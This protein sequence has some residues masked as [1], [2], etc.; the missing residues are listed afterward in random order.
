[1]CLKGELSGLSS[2]CVCL[3]SELPVI[4]KGH[5][6]DGH[7]PNLIANT[8]HSTLCFSVDCL[9][10]CPHMSCSQGHFQHPHRQ[11]HGIFPV[12]C[13]LTFLVEGNL[14]ANGLEWQKVLPFP[15]SFLCDSPD[16]QNP[17]ATQRLKTVVDGI[18]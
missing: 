15:E 11:L 2:V 18:S 10:T 14:S 8:M 5:S 1:M 12:A 7:P 9:R 6:P 13:L 3:L 16:G 4:S 17:S